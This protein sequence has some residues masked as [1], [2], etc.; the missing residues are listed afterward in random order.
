MTGQEG[1]TAAE[2]RGAEARREGGEAAEAQGVQGSTV[3][4]LHL[5]RIFFPRRSF[6]ITSIIF[7]ARLSAAPCRPSSSL[8]PPLPSRLDHHGRKHECRCQL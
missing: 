5:T 7:A 6:K 3:T 2:P 1:S 4:Y 8:A